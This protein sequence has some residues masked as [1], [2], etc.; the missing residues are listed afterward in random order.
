M[1][2]EMDIDPKTLSEDQVIAA[3][4]NQCR[5]A[6]SY[7]YYVQVEIDNWRTWPEGL[8]VYRDRE[9]ANG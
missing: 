5:R 6:K 4:R 7:A 1:A 8:V 3:I 2:M 9:V